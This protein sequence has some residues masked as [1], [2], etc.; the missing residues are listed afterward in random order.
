LYSLGHSD[1][2]GKKKGRE[3]EREGKERIERREEEVIFIIYYLYLPC[4][5]IPT[6]LY[7]REGNSFM[8]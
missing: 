6:Q 1:K 2:K 3:E 7:H 8:A 5:K 4:L